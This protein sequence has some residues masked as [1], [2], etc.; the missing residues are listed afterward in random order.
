MAANAS[1]A[2]ENSLPTWLVNVGSTRASVASVVSVASA[3]P[4]PS[5]LNNV[6]P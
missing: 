5:A 1:C 3:A 6:T 4:L 2:G